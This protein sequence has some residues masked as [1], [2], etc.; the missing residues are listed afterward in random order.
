M[1][2]RQTITLTHYKEIP[3][4]IHWTFSIIVVL[5]GYLAVTRN[6]SINQTLAFS[7]LILV[8][9]VCVILHEFGHALTAR[10][11]GIKTRDIILMPIG[12]IARLE[13]LPADPLKEISI[14]IAGPLVNLIIAA[15]TYLIFVIK[16]IGWIQPDVDFWSTINSWIGFLHL[17]LI[18][19]LASFV[20]NLFPILPMDGGRILR[21]LLSMKTD[22][23]NASRMTRVVSLLLISAV[24][25]ILM[26]IKK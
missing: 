3:I 18:I 6:L 14:A 19:N 2:T 8:V 17:V 10:R 9:F 16:G 12:G 26:Y 22:R 13:S 21:A 11:Y 15:L 25:G 20:I 1:M 23:K 24:F 7:L 4:K 5:I